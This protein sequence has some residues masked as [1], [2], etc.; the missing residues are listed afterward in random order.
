MLQAKIELESAYETSDPWGYEGHPDDARR[1]AELLGILP[2]GR[3]RRVLDIGCGNG[4]VTFALPGD[5]IVGVDISDNA[6][7]HAK[8]AATRRPEADRYSFR[9]GSI[10]EIDEL[11]P[12]AHFDLIVITGVL[13]PQYIAQA[14]QAVRI[15]VDR[16]LAPGGTLVCCH[17]DAWYQP[18][19][20][21]NRIDQM[22]YP[23]RNHTH[24]LEVYKK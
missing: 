20:W 15:K 14:K 16:L 1:R 19:F 7:E 21:F 13:Y 17:I 12:P 24:L 6:I 8:S 9:T 2:R 3:V 18:F 11:F 10:F 4:F 22:M 23:Y 5:E